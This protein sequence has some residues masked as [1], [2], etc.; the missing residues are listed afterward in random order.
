MAP[1]FLDK[2]DFPH[3]GKTPW[4]QTT[5]KKKQGSTNIYSLSKKKKNIAYDEKKIPWAPNHNVST[6]TKKQ[7]RT[8][9]VKQFLRQ[10]PPAVRPIAFSTSPNLALYFSFSKA[11]TISLKA[12]TPTSCRSCLSHRSFVKVVIFG[13]QFRL[14][15]NVHVCRRGGGRKWVM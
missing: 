10:T 15:R 4:P 11:R 1:L 12:S 9:T 14:W 7:N 13:T 2:S 8:C 3:D 6:G 5:L